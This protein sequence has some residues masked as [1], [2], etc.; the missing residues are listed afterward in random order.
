METRM[1]IKNHFVL[2]HGICHGAWCWYKVIPLLKMAG[3][4]VTAIDLGA[5][6][7]HPKKI[8]EISSFY[9]YSQPLME[10]LDSLPQKDEEKEKVV[11]VGHSF[12]GLCISYAMQNFPQKISVAV[13]VAAYM[14]KSNNPPADLIF[15]FFKRSSADSFMDCKF[16]TV[17]KAEEEG[18]LEN[19]PETAA[20]GSEYMASIMYQHCQPEDLELGKMLV[21]PNGFFIEEMKKES[22]LTEE[23]FG[24]VKKVYVLCEDDKVMEEEFQ[25]FIIDYSP[26]QQVIS[27]PQ[28]GHMVMLSK[29]QHFCKCL[30]EI[31]YKF[32]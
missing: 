25:R 26:P 16:T 7:I 21:R 29:P 8:E 5:C 30:L 23:N 1:M 12:S 13:F 14:P 11:L 32:S 2:V 24:S 18:C 22:L 10:F 31:A 17:S 3:H 4:K 28:S 15:E 20:L 9:D 6:G 19:L 27:I